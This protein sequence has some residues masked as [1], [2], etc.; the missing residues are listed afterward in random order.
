MNIWYNR[1][2]LRI[3]LPLNYETETD[4]DTDTETV[5]TASAGKPDSRLPEVEFPAKP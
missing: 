3:K 2:G 5:E 4:I 1:S